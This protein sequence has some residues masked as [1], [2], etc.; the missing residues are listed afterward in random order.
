MTISDDEDSKQVELGLSIVVARTKRRQSDSDQ[1]SR[2]PHLEKP[3]TP[4]SML[5]PALPKSVRKK[6]TLFEAVEIR[7]MGG[8]ELKERTSV[9]PLYQATNLTIH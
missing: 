2:S 4:K 9:R 8:D 3:F 7:R 6:R 1:S 5:R